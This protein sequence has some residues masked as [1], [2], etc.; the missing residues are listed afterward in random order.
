MTY[1]YI[2]VQYDHLYNIYIALYTCVNFL[3]TI[4]T[5]SNH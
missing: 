3:F 1:V 2:Y 4:Q 5:G